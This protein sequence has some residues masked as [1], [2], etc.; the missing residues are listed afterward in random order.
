MTHDDG[1]FT[2]DGV[3]CGDFESF[4]IGQSSLA[5][6]SEAGIIAPINYPQANRRPDGLIVDRN[7]EIPRVI[8][9]IERK[10]VGEMSSDYQIHTILQECASKYNHQLRCDLL[11]LTDGT[12]SV[13]ALVDIDSD[14]ENPD[15]VIIHTSPGV[16][17]YNHANTATDQGLE[18][19]RQTI[20]SLLQ[21]R[22]DEVTG[23]MTA[24]EECNPLNILQPVWTLLRGLNLREE[25]SLAAFLE[26]II[27]KFLSDIGV[28]FDN[29][30]GDIYDFDYVHSHNNSEQKLGRYIQNSRPVLQQLLPHGEDGTSPIIGFGM[31]EDGVPLWDAANPNHSRIFSD[32]LGAISQGGPILRLAD[33]FKH[34]V[35]E[36]F[37]RFS[38]EAR[39]SNAGTFFTPRNVCTAM[40]RMAQLETLPP[41]SILRDDSCGTG[42]LLVSAMIQFLALLTTPMH[43]IH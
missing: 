14:F 21:N 33:E 38:Q 17:L 12:R 24:P 6:L 8:L 18:Q 25:Q 34:R 36:N 5:Q 3:A 30:T 16:P 31:F 32:V 13:W 43:R 29:G 40:L 10:N 22:P 9:I 39:D 11:A 35:I 42:G 2:F 37:L 28:S 4:A 23:I 20:A 19:L 27:F 41:N 1:S 15:Y 7:T 26:L